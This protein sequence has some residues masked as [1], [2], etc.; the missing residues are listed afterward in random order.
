[1]ATWQTNKAVDHSLQQLP[2]TR[3]SSFPSST[4]C[5]K[6]TNQELRRAFAPELLRIS[7]KFFA[8]THIASQPN[9]LLGANRF[10]E[11]KRVVPR[12]ALPCP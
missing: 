9:L 8:N 11:T 3:T 5:T 12:T 2:A 1:M 10:N 4:T 7:R 6:S